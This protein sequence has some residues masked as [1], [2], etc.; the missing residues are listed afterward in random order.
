MVVDINIECARD[1]NVEGVAAPLTLA[2]NFFVAIV[3]EQTNIRTNLFAV[4]IVTSMHDHLE[5]ACILR[6][7]V[8]F[9]E[10]FDS[11][12]ESLNGFDNAIPVGNFAWHLDGYTTDE[13]K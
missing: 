10:E 7:P 9:F 8:L 4:S 11:E 2:G 6:L 1:A 13:E 5:V 3:S 12:S